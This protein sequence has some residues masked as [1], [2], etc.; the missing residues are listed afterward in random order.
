MARGAPAIFHLYQPPQFSR[1]AL[2]RVAELLPPRVPVISLSKGVETSSLQMMC[3]VT[4]D[5]DE[6]PTR[7]P[8]REL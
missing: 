3:E 7:S 4:R 1:A 5:I 6:M 2:S 8:H